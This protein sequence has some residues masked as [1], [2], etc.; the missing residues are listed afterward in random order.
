MEGSQVKELIQKWRA[1][2]NELK[3]K[4]A[5]L[6][7][8]RAALQEL[9]GQHAKTVQ[10]WDLEKANIQNTISL[11]WAQVSDKKEE[12]LRI[13]KERADL[14]SKVDER[15]LRN[16]EYWCVL[17]K[18]RQAVTTRLQE[19]EEKDKDA[20]ERLRDFREV[21]DES[22]Q[23]LIS[24]IRKLEDAEQQELVD[25]QQKTRQVRSKISEVVASVE[26]EKKS[27]A[28]EAAVRGWREKNDARRW[29][30]EEAN[31][32]EKNKGVWAEAIREADSM[33]FDNSLKELDAL[34][35]LISC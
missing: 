2:R 6:E 5:E 25:H 32:Y 7:K 1:L 19:L 20:K 27:W 21:R 26:A 29:L 4:N 9:E 28:L 23:Q 12:V 3:E 11:V 8:T 24:A 18:R 34:R 35:A 16:E 22:K 33:H 30:S 10:D 17:D 15:R 31:S 13:E 14:Q